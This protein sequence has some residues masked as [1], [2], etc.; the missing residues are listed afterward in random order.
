M[1]SEQ[2][3]GAP[4][5]VPPGE[6]EEARLQAHYALQVAAALAFSYIPPQPDDSHA[7]FGWEVDL[8][9]LISQ[10][11]PDPPPLRSGLRVAT[12]EL[13]LLREGGK[14]D[15]FELDG[16]TWSEAYDWMADT[17]EK[18][19]A[20]PV[21]RPLDRPPYD[22]PPHPIADG[23]AFSFAAPERFE[24]LAR[25][26]E[27]G[28]NLLEQLRSTEPNASLVRCWPHHFDLATLIRL[29][30]NE[31]GEEGRSIGVGL[32][33]GDDSY[34]EPYFYVSPYPEPETRRL[35]ALEFGGHWRREGFVGAI[36]PANRLLAE[37]DPEDRGR[38]AAAFLTAAVAHCRTLLQGS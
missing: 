25:W 38:R 15:S 26:F 18:R 1:A 37:A 31:S 22:I 10:T 16:A 23:Q 35:P 36:L 21:T 7:S 14:P 33:P 34:A 12:L 4:G 32:S 8:G 30:P 11:A 28:E 3:S 24:E 2:I 19:R 20:K 29:D 9:A 13:L 27:F 17:V 5:L 6:L